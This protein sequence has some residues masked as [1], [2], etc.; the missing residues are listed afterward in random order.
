MTLRSPRILVLALVAV[1]ALV[2]S[3]AM[4][5]RARGAPGPMVV[6]VDIYA[7]GHDEVAQPANL[8]VRAGGTTKIIVRNHTRLFHTFTIKALGISLLV[9]PAQ[10]NV[11]RS[12]SV[13]FVAPYGIYEWR[14][15]LCASTSH[16]RTHA[17]R[18]K[19][20]AIVNT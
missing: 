12:T 18:G 17:M 6:V 16:P 9:R 8:A 7:A 3:S 11:A 19:V 1:S 5:A 13:T 14:C 15:V 20:Y 10:G 2:V 4:A